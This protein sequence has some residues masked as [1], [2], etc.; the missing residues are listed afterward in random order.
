MFIPYEL[1]SKEHKTI[2]LPLYLNKNTYMYSLALLAIF[3]LFNIEFDT[4]EKALMVLGQIYGTELYWCLH[5]CLNT[6]SED[7]NLIFI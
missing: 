7:R 5:R 4:R 1:N 2:S 3:C 6:H